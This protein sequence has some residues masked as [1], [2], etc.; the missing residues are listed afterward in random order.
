MSLKTK[1]EI[2]NRN[3]YLIRLTLIIYINLSC[4]KIDYC[5]KFIFEN[6][7]HKNKSC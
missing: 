3:I 2:K 6:G 5:Y 4:L 7:S 1:C